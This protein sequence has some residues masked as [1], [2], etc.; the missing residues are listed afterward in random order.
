MKFSFFSPTQKGQNQV[1]KTKIWINRSLLLIGFLFVQS[2]LCQSAIAQ[3]GEVT[4]IVTNEA[5]APVP[6][7][8]VMVKQT[9]AGTS[10]DD[11]GR[12]SLTGSIGQTLVISAVGFNTQEFVITSFSGNSVKIL[13]NASSMNEVVVVGYTTQKRVSNQCYFIYQWRPTGHYQE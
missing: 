11:A 13:P 9:K 8:S 10:T 6:K 4:G 1:G 7:A 5:G 12:F 2:I 3:T